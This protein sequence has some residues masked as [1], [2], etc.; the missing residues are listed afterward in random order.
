MK[1]KERLNISFLN[2]PIQSPSLELN[3]ALSEKI[4]IESNKKHLIFMCDRA[5]KSCSVNVLNKKSICNICRYKAKQG[6]KK[7]KERNPNSELIKI[8]RSDL[9]SH[10]LDLNVLEKNVNQEI[11]LGVH[12]TIATQLRLEDMNLLNKKWIKIKEKMLESS[13]SLFAYFDDFLLNNSVDKF[14]IFNGRLSCS[15]PLI[16]ASKK[17]EVNYLLFDAAVNGKVPMYSINEMFLSIEFEKRNSLVTYLKFFRESKQLAQK[18]FTLKR[19]KIPVNDTIY[20]QNQVDNFIDSSIKKLTKPIISIFVSSDDEYRFVGSDWSNYSIVDQIES[21]NELINS[22]L[23]EKYD[24][25][26][27]M[28][29]NQSNIHKSSMNKYK[30]LSRNVLVMFPNDKTDTYALIE[31]SELII[32]YSSSVALDANYMRKPVVQ[33]GPS[34]FLKFLIS[35][36][37]KTTKEAVSLILENKFKIMPIRG[38]IISYTYYMKPSFTLKAYNYVKDGVY[39]YGGEIIKPP[40]YLRILAVPAKL[41]VYLE[42]G[43]LEI[44]KN[45][46][47]HLSNLIFGERKVK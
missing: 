16:E 18:Y 41:Y 8:K 1:N 22:K 35:T 33:I 45:F 14:V 15:R 38:S 17:N 27:K 23:K 39:E 4:H 47:M 32:C 26:V 21:I 20:T 11:L 10:K 31:N 34:I 25:V 6:F 9:F 29:P 46:S 40:L 43:D 12:S 5:L 2:L 19:K 3:F 36:F 28:H 24:F 42:K 30:N 44:F 7:F 13:Y 37:A